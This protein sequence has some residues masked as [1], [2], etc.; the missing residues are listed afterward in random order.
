MVLDGIGVFSD[1]PQPVIFFIGKFAGMENGDDL[2]ALAF[3]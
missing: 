2:F 3:I 1:S